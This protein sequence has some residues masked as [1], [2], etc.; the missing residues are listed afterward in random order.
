M[1]LRDL[2]VGD[3][4]MFDEGDMVMIYHGSGYYS[5]PNHPRNPMIRFFSE[6]DAGVVRIN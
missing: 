4:F 5:C 6:V 2:N 3:H 1:E